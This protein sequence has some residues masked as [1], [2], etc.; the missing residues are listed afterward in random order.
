MTS[1][2][3]P[4][5]KL[6]ALLGVLAAFVLAL[7]TA[8]SASA[9]PVV[10]RP[11]SFQV[12]NAN[13]SKLACSTDGKTYTIRGH[14]TG[15]KAELESPRAATLYLHGLGLGEFF[16]NDHVAKGYDFA[17]GL[18]RRGHVSVT[19]NRLGYNTSGKPQG[20]GSCIGGQATIAHQI[21]GDLKSGHYKGSL[22]PK[23]KRVGLIGHS[24]GGQITEVESYSFGDAAA[25][26]VLAYADQGASPF[27]LE[28]G[29]GATEVCEAGGEPSNENSGPGGYAKLGQ[30]KE[31]GREAFFSSAS[32]K[33]QFETLNILTANPCGDL[34]SYAAAPAT[35]LANIGSITVPVLAVQGGKDTLF[36]VP[37]VKAQ[38][39][40]FTGSSA[41]TYAEL[42]NSA[43]ALT[44]ESEHGRLE[45]IVA[46]FLSK[47]HL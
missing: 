20:L 8:G 7:G 13:E 11:I 27:Q 16:W 6:S 26:G 39:A 35:D 38:S 10:E 1:V 46:K 40:L 3:H 9:A 29:K 25:I 43:H 4:L 30:T 15:T 21:I 18:A 17:E 41:V 33:V 5:P 36:P 32:K 23:F 14:L 2:A 42:P 24:A 12:T 22:H 19:I 34:A 28:L 45:A 31:Q 37:D 44:L 47:N